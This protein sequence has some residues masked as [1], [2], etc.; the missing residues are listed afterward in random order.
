MTSLP[1]RSDIEGLRGVAVILVIAFHL[2]LPFVTG[3]YIGVDVFYVISGFLITSIIQRG[4]TLQ[5]A[6][7]ADFYN[8]RIKRL[9]PAFLF[10]LGVTTIGC[11][12]F[13]L[14][15][16]LIS[17]CKSVRESLLLRSNHF[18]ARET[19]NYFAPDAGDLP[20]LHTWSLSIEWQYYLVFPAAFLVIKRLVTQRWL[21]AV[22]LGLTVVLV[23]V[24][25]MAVRQP[26]GAYFSATARAFEFFLGALVALARQSAVPRT[27]A[28]TLVAL[29]VAGLACV[30]VAF[31]PQTP[32]PGTNALIVC[33][34]AAVSLRYGANSTILSNRV[35]V[36]IGRRSYS[37][38][39]WHWPIVALASYLQLRNSAYAS[40]LLLIP[41]L[42]MSEFTY[43]FI[44]RPGIRLQAGIPAS[45][46]KLVVLPIL[47]ALAML[48]IVR[49]FEG[50]PGRLGPEAARVFR[51]LK[52]FDRDRKRC[53]D[54]DAGADIERCAFGDLAATD[55][56]LLLGDS[57][58][59]HYWALVE[60]LARHAHVK[61][62]GLT[63]GECLAL[64]GARLIRHG[65]PYTY[66]TDVTRDHYAT[67]ATGKYKYVF[68]GQRWIG[69]PESELE[70]LEPTI[71]AIINSGAIPVL[72]EPIAENGT[73]ASKCFFRHIK[74]RESYR[75]ECT[76]S[77]DNDFAREKKQFV[78]ELIERVRR[79]HPELIV[80]DPK[81][82]QCDARKCQTVIDGIPI[83]S[84]LHHLTDFGA[85]TLAARLLRRSGNPL[86]VRSP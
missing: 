3:G 79:R 6:S 74:L 10:V 78:D 82:V 14:P 31:S 76:I 33:L 28:N 55:R 42:L 46:S 61:V 75:D 26:G 20:L 50:F 86:S 66:C 17:Y 77:A 21:F 24:S 8:R 57:H 60:T 58:A 23:M 65:V 47:V 64:D 11:M 51:T 19:S 7:L 56:A 2:D 49:E 72:L 83:Y 71:A 1:F 62:Y 32:F 39:L 45:F 30:A 34:L 68:L 9:L 69:Y 15:D 22:M 67:I 41:I 18:F 85:E 43:S 81:V 54:L 35:M 73:N 44:E 29:S 5:P 27:A 59:Q 53:N 12:W 84:D 16:D 37:L 38:Y 36:H 80:V 13:M 4:T 48:Q 40:A 25:A 63:N 52:E 70:L